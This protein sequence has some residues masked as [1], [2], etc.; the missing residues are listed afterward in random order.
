MYP[1]TVTLSAFRM[2]DEEGGDVV[3]SDVAVCV[4]RLTEWIW[5]GCMARVGELFFLARGLIT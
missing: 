5:V 1:T 2:R 3:L 4:C